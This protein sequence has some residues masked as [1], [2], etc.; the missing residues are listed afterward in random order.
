M[1]VEHRVGD[2]FAQTDLAAIGQ[3][4]NVKA[5]MGSGIAPIFKRYWPSMFSEYKTLCESGRFTVGDVHAWQAPSGVWIYNL[6]SQHYPGKDARLDA[7]ATALPK[8][9]AH[10]EAHDVRSVGLPRIG[11]G[12]GGLRWADVLEVI[13]RAADPSPL[14]V[15][16]VSLPGA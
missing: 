8:M 7:I 1:S 16:V 4:V 2:L 13:H 14:R 3:G 10:M 9:L 5:K 12:I 15:V 11:A 6:A